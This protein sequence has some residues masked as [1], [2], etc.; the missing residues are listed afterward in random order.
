MNPEPRFDVALTGETLAGADPDQVA[1]TLARLFKM[2]PDKARALLAGKPLVVKKNADESTARKFQVALRQAGA[3]CELRPLSA[4]ATP[5]P[6]APQPRQSAAA[7][8]TDHADPQTV[9]TLRTGGTGFTG[10]FEVAAPGSDLDTRRRPPPPAMPDTQHL[11]IAEPGAELETLRDD[12][13][14]AAP[15]ISH[16]SLREE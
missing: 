10:R 1:A 14:P 2:P 6:V 12:T 7:A 8:D 15:D 11:S 3:R 9:G 5:P 16:L 13:P 4:A